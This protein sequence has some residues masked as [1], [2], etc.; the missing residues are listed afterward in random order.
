MDA[1][2]TSKGC[3]VLSRYAFQQEHEIDIP[4]TVQ[5]HGSGRLIS[6]H[7]RIK[8][9]LEKCSWQYRIYSFVCKIQVSQIHCLHKLT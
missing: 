4:F 3:S 7:V 6:V 1:P 8:D 5:F 9:N 2:E